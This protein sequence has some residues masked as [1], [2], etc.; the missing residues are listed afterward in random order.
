MAQPV[1]TPAEFAAIQESN[2]RA[3]EKKEA[4]AKVVRTIVTVTKTLS[5]GLAETIALSVFI[6]VYFTFTGL[7][8]LFNRKMPKEWLDLMK[9]PRVKGIATKVAKKTTQNEASEEVVQAK[10]SKNKYKVVDLETGSNVRVS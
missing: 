1:I 3:L 4:P 6:L 9:S 2:R 5:Y 10:P 8:I 7:A